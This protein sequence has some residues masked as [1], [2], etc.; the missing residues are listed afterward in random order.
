MQQVQTI[1]EQVKQLCQDAVEMAATQEIHSL[2]QQLHEAQHGL[3]KQQ[4]IVQ[5]LQQKINGIEQQQQPPPL[6]RHEQQQRTQQ[7]QQLDSK[8]QM[9]CKMQLMINHWNELDVNVDE[10]IDI[11]TNALQ[12]VVNSAG[13]MNKI[14]AVWV[15]LQRECERLQSESKLLELMSNQNG[16]VRLLEDGERS[17]YNELMRTRVH[18][19][20]HCRQHEEQFSQYLQHPCAG[21][22]VITSQQ[23]QQQ[24]VDKR[25]EPCEDSVAATEVTEAPPPPQ[26]TL[27]Q[28]L[29][30]FRQEHFFYQHEN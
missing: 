21:E 25:Q 27:Y 20:Q 4:Q 3:C 19:R 11:L 18:L 13:Y 2:E 12:A 17:V 14:D 7:T 8:Q 9:D 24:Q 10:R 22:E 23:Y 15:V 28:S 16:L 30:Q 29:E 6:Q 1:D 5:L 26:C